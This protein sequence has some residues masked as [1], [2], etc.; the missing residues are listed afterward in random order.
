VWSRF[1]EENLYLAARVCDEDPLFSP[2]L[3]PGPHAG[4]QLRIMLDTRL[5]EDIRGARMDADD[6]ELILGPA[7]AQGKA[8]LVSA[9]GRAEAP[10][11]V[12]FARTDRG[13]DAEIALPW[14]SLGGRAPVMGFNIALTDADGD[15]TRDAELSWS[16]AEFAPRAPRGFGQ[17]I[18]VEDPAP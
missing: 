8:W 17:L 4:D 7:I 16:G 5:L 15:L 18:L 9:T 14:Q 6:Y 2:R 3:E 13:W 1:D 11:P 10:A 12:H